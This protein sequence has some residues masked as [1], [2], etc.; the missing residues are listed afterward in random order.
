M[1]VR[2]NEERKCGTRLQEAL[3][4][5]ALAL[6]RGWGDEGDT[7]ALTSALLTALSVQRF[8]WT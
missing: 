2:H 4:E 7:A 5:D 6:D 8:W 3:W 1:G